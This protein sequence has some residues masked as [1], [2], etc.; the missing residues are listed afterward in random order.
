MESSSGT[1]TLSNPYLLGM[2]LRE[3]MLLKPYVVGLEAACEETVRTS[4][5]SQ[6]T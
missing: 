4:L 1:T 5:I 2:P 6:P 3:Q